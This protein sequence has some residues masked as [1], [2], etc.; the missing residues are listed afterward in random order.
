MRINTYI[1]HL[2]FAL[3]VLLNSVDLHAFEHILEGDNQPEIESCEVCSEFT[4]TTQK[5]FIA[6][7]IHYDF[8]APLVLPEQQELFS[9]QVN[10]Q[11][12][13]QLGQYFNRPP[14]LS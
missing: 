7:E 5:N 9:F 10:F 3:T 12:H 4:V 14:P 8:K 11:K 1:L 6:E 2:L 13:Q